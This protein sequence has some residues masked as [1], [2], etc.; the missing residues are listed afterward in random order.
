M[1]TDMVRLDGAWRVFS[2]RQVVALRDV[3]FSIR[4]GDYIAITG[5]SG[6]GK[7]TLLHLAGG[8][9]RPTKGRV[10]FDGSEL[11][12][13]A[14]RAALRARRVGFV[15]QSFHLLGGL[16]AA[17][18]VEIPMFGVLRSER[19][20]QRRVAWLLDRVG[21]AHR[22]LHRVSELSGGECQRVAIARALANSPDLMLA[23]EP[24]GNLD[25][26]S[27]NEILALLD[28][29]HRREGITLVLVT[30]DTGVSRRAKRIVGLFD[31][32][33]VSDTGNGDAS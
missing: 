19:E 25:S 24:T 15:F 30:H 3:E 18:N 10:F 4:R 13:P 6:S 8:L 32:R 23:D 1:A 9:D 14:D 12:A 5:P 20:R 27:A 16:T 7:S 33:I 17:E 21:L 11:K 26:E 31:G 2:R 29:L 28:D 22:G